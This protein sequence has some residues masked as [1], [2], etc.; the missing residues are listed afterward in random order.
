[1]DMHARGV[2]ACLPSPE[3]VPPAPPRNGRGVVPLSH[4]STTISHMELRD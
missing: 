4:N 1:M 3:H 2:A